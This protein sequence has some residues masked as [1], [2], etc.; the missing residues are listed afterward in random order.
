F[1]DYGVFVYVTHTIA[2]STEL[3]LYCIGGTVIIEFS[4]ELATT[5]YSSKWYTHSVRVQRM[6]LL[7]IIR[8]QR[9]LVVK[10]PFFAPSLPTLTSILRF[11]GSLIAL[12]K[13]M[14]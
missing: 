7:I 14:I 3:F 9:S 13:S 6:V 12:V 2:V 5:V 8:A 10:V 11:T 4:S 1:S